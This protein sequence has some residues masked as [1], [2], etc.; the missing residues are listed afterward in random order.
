MRG[1]LQR[2]VAPARRRRSE[3]GGDDN[4]RTRNRRGRECAK[5]RLGY[6]EQRELAELPARIEQLEAELAALDARILEPAFYQ[7]PASAITAANGERAAKQS[8]LDAAYA[9]WQELDA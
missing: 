6:K 3:A 4:R 7:Q 1:W 5:K 8:L 9:R 2:L